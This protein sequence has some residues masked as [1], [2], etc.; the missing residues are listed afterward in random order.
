MGLLYSKTTNLPHTLSLSR[1]NTHTHT[2][3]LRLLFFSPLWYADL[4]LFSLMKRFG[5]Y[6]FH[7]PQPVPHKHPPGSGVFVMGQWWGFVCWISDVLLASELTL[8]GQAHFYISRLSRTHTQNGDINVTVNISLMS[9]AYQCVKYF[10]LCKCEGYFGLVLVSHILL[11][12]FL[13]GFNA[14]V[15]F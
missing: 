9:H 10:I 11:W 14:D 13:L 4:L 12:E 6:P 15:L 8:I 1:P 5:S 7:Y 2:H 3:T